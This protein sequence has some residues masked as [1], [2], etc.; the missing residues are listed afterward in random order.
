MIYYLVPHDSN[1]AVASSLVNYKRGVGTA[2]QP[3]VNGTDQNSREHGK[4]PSVIPDELLR[5]FHFTFLIR[6][7]R[8][9]IPSYFRCTVPPLD[10]I[11]GFYKFLP[12]EAGYSELRRFFDY[13]VYTGQVG[14]NVTQQGGNESI[15]E[16][17]Y[18]DDAANATKSGGPPS[19][20]ITVIDADELLSDPEGIVRT[21]CEATGIEFK[22]DMLSWDDPKDEGI[23]QKAFEK[24][25]GF[26]D[27]VIDSKGIV[28]KPKVRLRLRHRTSR[29]ELSCLVADYRKS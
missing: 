18:P 19:V 28:K 17:G 27:D 10:K 8:A 4:N 15:S 22:L 23:S 14:P 2:K 13:L 12:S 6:H 7:P 11:T 24:W 16:N 26:H 29:N 25:P 20:A 1:P 5:D 9:S 3:T 21:Y